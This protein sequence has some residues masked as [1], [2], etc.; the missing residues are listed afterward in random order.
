[1]HLPDVNVWLALTFESHLH[2]RA[3]AQWFSRGAE[4]GCAFCRVTQQGF[5]RLATNPSAFGAE[6]VSGTAAW[7]LYDCFLADS[8]IS[9]QPEPPALE[10]QWRRFSSRRSYSPKVWTDAYLAA[11]ARTASM[12]LVSFDAGMR[13]YPG[14]HPVILG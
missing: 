12:E 13:D 4:Q 11:F 2:H 5:L 6:A 3:A 14:L 7:D 1:M 9:F 10:E 8:R